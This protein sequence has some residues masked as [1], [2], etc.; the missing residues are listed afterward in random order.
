M[1]KK[2][3]P[4]DVIN[5]FSPLFQ[6]IKEKK[7]PFDLNGRCSFIAQKIW[8]TI[9]F[10]LLC[11]VSIDFFLFPVCCLFMI[12]FSFESLL[13]ILNLCIFFWNF[14]L[15]RCCWELLNECLRALFFT[16]YLKSFDGI[17]KLLFLLAQAWTLLSL[18]SFSWDLD[19]FIINFG[20]GILM[21]GQLHIWKIWIQL[22]LWRVNFQFSKTR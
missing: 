22:N 12:S 15:V 18:E 6:Y 11:A 9:A 1:S 5:N 7:S 14:I 20:R 17:N 2:S 16:F 8:R 3:W 19:E 21:M 13:L 10:S 4:H